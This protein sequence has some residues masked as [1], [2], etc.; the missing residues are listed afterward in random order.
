MSS[1]KYL[2]RPVLSSTSVESIP[3]LRS[4]KFFSETEI[5][6]FY[7]ALFAYENVLRL[8]VPVKNEIFVQESDPFQYFKAYP[9]FIFVA[10]HNWRYGKNFCQLQVEV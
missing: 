4:A 8:Q 5:G 9:F 2:R 1:K 7:L 6:Y 3:S 10:F